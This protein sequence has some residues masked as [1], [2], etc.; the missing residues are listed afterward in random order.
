MKRNA[1]IVA[2]LIAVSPQAQGDAIIYPVLGDL[3]DWDPTGVGLWSSLNG[4]TTLA[5]PATGG[6]TGGW[7]QVTFS[8]TA[9]P[10][11]AQAQWYDIIYTS[12]TNLYTGTWDTNQTVR[13]DFWASNVPPGAVQVQWQSSTNLDV[14]GYTLT[15][16]ATGVWTSFS[17]PLANW[18]DWQYAGATEAQYLS[19]LSSIEWIGVY[20]YR[21][22]AALQ[23]YGIDN[24]A[25]VIPE[26]A[27]CLML[28]FALMT[29]GVSLRRK[30][31]HPQR[32]SPPQPGG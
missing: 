28:V 1:L 12:A 26:P 29:T 5:T 16:P 13:F 10:E 22:T 7:Q 11:H 24:F 8:Q 27:E 25:L 21:N 31:K 20:I 30:A 23:I 17:A 32:G 19:D 6:H 3:H 15:P 9:V 4:W 2:V 14:W 18:A